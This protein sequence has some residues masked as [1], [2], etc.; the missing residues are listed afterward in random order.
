MKMNKPWSV[1]MELRGR[2][3]CDASMTEAQIPMMGLQG[4][5]WNVTG[6]VKREAYGIGGLWN[7]GLGG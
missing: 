4:S 2:E 5:R 3:V 7:K 1:P 6:E